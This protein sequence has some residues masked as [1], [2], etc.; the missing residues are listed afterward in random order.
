[1]DT[2]FYTR[3]L[4]IGTWFYTRNHPANPV[5]E[6][7]SKT[8]TSR[9][10]FLTLYVNLNA[11][12][13]APLR[14]SPGLA[15]GSPS[16][17]SSPRKRGRQVPQKRRR[18]TP[19]A[20]EAATRV[21]HSTAEKKRSSENKASPPPALRKCGGG[22]STAAGGQIRAVGTRSGVRSTEF[23]KTIK[24]IACRAA[25]AATFRRPINADFYDYAMM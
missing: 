7:V 8:V 12:R 14:G 19:C 13:G 10:R 20:A 18:S 22:F 2:W 5:L 15:A 3:R 1:M 16:R 21:T 4:W 25:I 6:R 9:A 24:K 17:L 11:L 23:L